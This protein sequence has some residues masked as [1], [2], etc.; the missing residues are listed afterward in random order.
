MFNLIKKEVT[1][2]RVAQFT[3]CE[4]NVAIYINFSEKSP[5][6]DPKQEEINEKIKNL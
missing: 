1:F 5:H 2:K 6:E 4:S 3:N